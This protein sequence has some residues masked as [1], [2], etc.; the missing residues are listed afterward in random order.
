M[1]KELSEVFPIKISKI[2]LKI[3]GEALSGFDLDRIGIA[4]KKIIEEHSGALY[5]SHLISEIKKQKA[6]YL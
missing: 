6:G 4:R 3:W 2:S 1:I 5:P